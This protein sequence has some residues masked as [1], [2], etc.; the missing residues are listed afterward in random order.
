MAEEQRKSKQEITK[1]SSNFLRGTIADELARDTSKFGS[2]DVGLL[3]FHGIYQQDD[4]DAR[5]Q[6]AADASKAGKSYIFMIRTKVPGGKLTA[7]Q[8]LTELS[9]GELGNGSPYHTRQGFSA[10]CRQGNLWA[11]FMRLTSL[12][13]TLAACGDVERNVMPAPHLATAFRPT[14]SHGRR[15][16]PAPGTPDPRVL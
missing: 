15:H 7:E 16:R 2:D 6:R 14:A 10:R 4:R 8:F 11:A 9:L 1:E 13:T 12:L 3:K 5:K